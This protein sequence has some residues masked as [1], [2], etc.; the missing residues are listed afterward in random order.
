MMDKKKIIIYGSIALIVVLVL[1]LVFWSVNN[2]QNQENQ[3]EVQNPPELPPQEVNL[4]N[5]QDVEKTISETVKE[6]V[7][8]SV[9]HDGSKLVKFKNQDKQAIPFIDFEKATGIAVNKDLRGYLDNT[10][11]K[12][13][14]CPGSSGGKDF[15]IYLGYNVAKAYVNLYPD[16]V[17][18]MKSWEKTMLPDLHAVLFPEVNLGESELNQPLQFKDG[19]FRYAEV[20]LPGG[21]TGSINYRVSDN[22]VIISASPSCL[23]KIVQIYEPY[24]P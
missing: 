16:T 9:V 6:P 13:F 10:D 17:A 1:F 3:P 23:E 8:E 2:N 4:Q 21:K 20:R 22:G 15:G 11:Y 12:T 24:Q 7:S 18:W 14:Y 19:K 5:V